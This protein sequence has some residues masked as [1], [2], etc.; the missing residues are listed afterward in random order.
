MQ[1]KLKSGALDPMASGSGSVKPNANEEKQTMHNNKW[2]KT[3]NDFF[4]F[5]KLIP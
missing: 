4:I 3:R 5:E 1:G 2:P